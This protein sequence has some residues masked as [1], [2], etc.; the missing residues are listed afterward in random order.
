MRSA[1]SVRRGMLLVGIALLITLLSAPAALA[2]KPA[3]NG[4]GHSGGGTPPPPTG[5]GPYVVCIDPGHGGSDSGATASYNGTTLLEKDLTLEIAAILGQELTGQNYQVA[6]TRT[7]DVYMTNTQRAE[8]CN[9]ANANVVIAI[10]LN[11]TSSGDTIDYFQDFWG[12]KNKDLAFSQT[13]TNNYSIPSADDPSVKLTDNPVGQF[14]S[15]VMLKTN[16]PA[17][18]AETVFLSDAAEQQALYHGINTAGITPTTVNFTT[19]QDATWSGTRQMTIATALDQ[20]INAWFTG[21]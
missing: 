5:G 8:A 20:G 13:I 2:A 7:S 15:S 4:H 3:S 19:L 1:K 9:A 21:Q 10:H 6:Y 12:K 14:A 18:L 16:C 11:A 17:T